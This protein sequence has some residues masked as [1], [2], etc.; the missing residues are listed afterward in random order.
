MKV[1][2]LTLFE[3]MV[4]IAIFS[5]VLL[6]LSQLF[7]SYGNW[8]ASLNTRE[9]AILQAHDAMQMM[10]AEA[11]GAIAINSPAIGASSPSLVVTLV[12]PGQARFPSGA[13]N[14]TPDQGSVTVQYQVAAQGLTR[15]QNSQTPLLLAQKIEGM[16][17][18]LGADRRLEVSLSVRTGSILC[19][20]NQ[21]GFYWVKSL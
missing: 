2:G 4:S 12:E 14:W 8:N 11:Q 5:L 13:P 3:V 1:R 6:V 10:I 15:T 21:S 9:E 18:R 16:Q 7:Q 17:A 19:N 20:L